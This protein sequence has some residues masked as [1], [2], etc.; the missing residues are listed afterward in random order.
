[1]KNF[2]VEV[3]LAIV[4]CVV[5]FFAFALVDAHY[6]ISNA[7]KTAVFLRVTHVY[8]D[9]CSFTFL[10]GSVRCLVKLSDESIIKTVDPYV[11]K[12]LVLYK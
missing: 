4:F 10:G 11:G 8:S 1:M 2:F 5:S 9:T 3:G 12:S 7:S 6:G